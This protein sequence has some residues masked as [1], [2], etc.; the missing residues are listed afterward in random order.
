MPV[1]SAAEMVSV[2]WPCLP[3]KLPGDVCQALAVWRPRGEHI[4]ARSRRHSHARF[5]CEILDPEVR[6]ASHTVDA[7]A[8]QPLAIW[9]ETHPTPRFAL[10]RAKVVAVPVDGA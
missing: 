2:L 10:L 6:I 8:H 7:T 4:G 3:G 5:S 9:R 1:P